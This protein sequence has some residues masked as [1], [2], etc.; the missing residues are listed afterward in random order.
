MK[1]FLTVLVGVSLATMVA[2]PAFGHGGDLTGIHA[3]A[4]GSKSLRVVAADETCRSNESALDWKI[5]GVAGL[6]GAAGPTGA[7]GPLGP[8]GATG[9]A[10][11][12]GAPGVQ[13]IAGPRGPQGPAGPPAGP[14][15]FEYHSRVTSWAVGVFDT[16]IACRVAGQV[17]VGGGASGGFGI[18]VEQSY[19]QTDSAWG[20]RVRNDD[21]AAKN[22]TLYAICTAATG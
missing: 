21:T 5:Q 9:P 6:A 12:T 3:C 17:V 4:T 15:S 2:V 1:R 16:S 19:P 14:S 13:G 8:T 10:G 11:P 22:V 20:L 7:I 18:V